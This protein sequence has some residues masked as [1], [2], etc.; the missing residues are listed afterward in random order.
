[1]QPLALRLLQAFRRTQGPVQRQDLAA[2]ALRDLQWVEPGVFGHQAAGHVRHQVQGRFQYFP[3][4]RGDRDP[5]Q[6]AM[7][8]GHFTNRQHRRGGAGA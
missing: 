4:T 5:V 1:M 7:T 3:R 8:L 6:Q 2:V